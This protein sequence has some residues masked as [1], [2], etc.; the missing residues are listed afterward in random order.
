MSQRIERG[1]QPLGSILFYCKCIKQKDTAQ[2][3][4]VHGSMVV[5]LMLRG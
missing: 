3:L 1:E 2:R 4:S 5:E